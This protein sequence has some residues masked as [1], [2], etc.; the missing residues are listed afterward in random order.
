MTDLSSVPDGGR[1]GWIAVLA[2]FARNMVWVG[3]SKG[4]GVM[5]PTLQVQ[6]ASETWILGW[7]TAMVFAMCGV[8]GTVDQRSMH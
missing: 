4:L 3:V 7:I 1:R 5:L 6:F 2:M 8:I